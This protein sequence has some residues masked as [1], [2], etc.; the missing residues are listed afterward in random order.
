TQFVFQVAGTQGATAVNAAAPGGFNFG[1][2]TRGVIVP[3]GDPATGGN[4]VFVQGIGGTGDTANLQ[5]FLSGTRIDVFEL[6]AVQGTGNA[7]TTGGVAT[8]V[9]TA[10][11]NGAGALVGVNLVTTLTTGEAIRTARIRT[12]ST[13]FTPNPFAPVAPNPFLT[14]LLDNLSGAAVVARAGITEIE[15]V[16]FAFSPTLLKVCKIAGTNF[17]LNT[18]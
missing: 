5:T 3:A 6:G 15:F 9:G 7:A 13:F 16:N 10:A 8:N 2:V 1:A 12:S 11:P 14:P 18:P 17:P 4:C